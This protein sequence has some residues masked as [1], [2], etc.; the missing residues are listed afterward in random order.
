MEP[1]AFQLL[2]LD[3]GGTYRERTQAGTAFHP[4]NLK[5][6]DTAVTYDSAVKPHATKYALYVQ[7]V[8]DHQ[9]EYV[10]I[11][12]NCRHKALNCPHPPTPIILVYMKQ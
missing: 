2:L 1:M 8:Y 5:Q 4:D 9:T 11:S 3:M 6:N 12:P 10:S 7:K